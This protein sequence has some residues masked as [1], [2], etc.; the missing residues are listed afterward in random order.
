M[1]L[2]IWL[3]YWIAY[4]LGEWTF[5]S[6]WVPVITISLALILF[7]VIFHVAQLPAR[8]KLKRLDTGQN[9][10]QGKPITQSE[11]ETDSEGKAVG[12]GG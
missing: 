10:P 4:I 6:T 3:G 12:I 11:P 7:A 5:F 9:D 2:V 1:T 8:A